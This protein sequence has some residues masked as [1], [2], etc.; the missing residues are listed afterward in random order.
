MK[1]SGFM[2]KA[3]KIIAGITCGVLVILAVTPVKAQ[4]KQAQVAP[5]V[6]LDIGSLAP[7]DGLGED[8]AP[9]LQL[10]AALKRSPKVRFFRLN[11][12]FTMGSFGSVSTALYDRL[13]HT[14]RFHYAYG[15][16]AAGNPKDNGDSH[17]IFTGVTEAVISRAAKA[18]AKEVQIDDRGYILDLTR[19]GCVSHVLCSPS[20]KQ[21][22]HR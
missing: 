10:S 18:H 2:P 9:L 21:R 17:L 4:P 1:Y 14:L 8:D 16:N 7:G 15:H 19:F 11:W 6:K 5:S 3:T 22:S 12:E 13:K 20:P